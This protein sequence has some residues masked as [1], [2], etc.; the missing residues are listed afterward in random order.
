MSRKLT[1]AALAL[2]LGGGVYL[3]SGTAEA[4]NM[5]F[6][7]ERSFSVVDNFRNVYYLSF[8]LFNGLGDIAGDPGPDGSPCGT[9][10]NGIVNADDALCDLFTDRDLS[11]GGAAMTLSLIDT[12]SCLFIGR[13]AQKTSP[14]NYLFI[15]AFTSDLT[16]SANRQ[17][18][19][20][21]NVGAGPTDP[22]LT[23]RAV[24]VGSHDPSFGGHT[25]SIA[26]CQR[27]FI[28]LPY[29]TMYRTAN[30]VLCG[31]E[32]VD[33]MDADMDGN[34]DTC[35]NGVYDISSG[36]SVVVQ[37]FINDP[38]SPNANRLI[39]RSVFDAGGSLFFLGPIYDLIPGEA[40]LIGMDTGFNDRVFLSPHF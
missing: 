26:G 29:H 24:V 16:N 2:V 11:N 39:G 7:L 13:T 28:N 1:A 15:G 25:L 10:P 18:G 3:A 33:W 12:S 23:N 9:G 30:E 6:K 20:L 40:Y 37:S 34:P 38:A 4:S 17:I 19:Y 21:I 27:D 36:V 8:P 32:G 5:G 14:T 35:D 22:P 31:L